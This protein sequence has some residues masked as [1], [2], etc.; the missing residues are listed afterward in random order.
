MTLTEPKGM[1][2]RTLVFKG[3]YYPYWIDCM[4]VHIVV[5]DAEVSHYFSHLIV[6]RV[7]YLDFKIR[8]VTV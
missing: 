1:Y 3:K 6:S 5:Y 8:N 7:P 2:D 4:Q